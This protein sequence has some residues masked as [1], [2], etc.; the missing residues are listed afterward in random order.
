MGS[1]KHPWDTGSGANC[2]ERLCM[3][4]T[5]RGFKRGISVYMDLGVPTVYSQI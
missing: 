5:A 2:H 3:R 1:N 4:L